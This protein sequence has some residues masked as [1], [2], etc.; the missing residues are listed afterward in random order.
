MKTFILACLALLVSVTAATA[1]PMANRHYQTEVFACNGTQ[2]NDSI[3]LDY[4][5]VTQIHAVNIIRDQLTGTNSGHLNVSQDFFSV[6]GQ[7]RILSIHDEPETWRQFSPNT[8]Q[9]PAAQAVAL[10]W[11]CVNGGSRQYTVE[12]WF[13]GGAA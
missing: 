1:V 5:Q 8:I 3:V 10:E 9:L 4:G 6:D 13:T 11:G 12:I 2:Y 7:F